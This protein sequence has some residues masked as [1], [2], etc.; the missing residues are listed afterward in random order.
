MVLKLDFGAAGK[1]LSAESEKSYERRAL[2]NQVAE[3]IY[4][5]CIEL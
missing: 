3:K 1:L 4:A 5:T 2:S